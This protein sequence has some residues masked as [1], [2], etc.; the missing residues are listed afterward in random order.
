M[1]EGRQ[2]ELNQDHRL[3]G[4]KKLGATFSWSRTTVELDLQAI[5]FSSSGAPLG[6]VAYSNARALDGGLR[7][8]GDGTSGEKMKHDREVWVYLELMPDDVSLIVFVGA[9]VEKG[10]LWHVE[11]ARFHLIQDGGEAAGELGSLSLE[12]MSCQ[13]A[14]LG[15]LRRDAGGWVVRATELL[16]KDGQ[17]FVDILEPTIGG[18]VRGVIAGAPNL[19]ESVFQLDQGAIVELPRTE[20]VHHVCAGLSWELPGG[21]TADLDVSAIL[22]DNDGKELC[23]VHVEH[24]A[25]QGMQL[26]APRS[27]PRGLR[28]VHLDLEA[29]AP[30]VQ[31]LFFLLNMTS[32]GQLADQASSVTCRIFTG[33]SG[34]QREFSSFTCA[35]QEDS[36]QHGLIVARLF[37]A[38]GKLRWAFEAVGSQC[39]GTS[40]AESLPEV[41]EYASEYPR[42]I[43]DEEE[44]SPSRSLYNRGS[45]RQSFHEDDD[46]GGGEGGGDSASFVG[47]SY[48]GA[49]FHESQ[50]WLQNGGGIFDHGVGEQDEEEAALLVKGEKLD[51]RAPPEPPQLAPPPQPEQA[52]LKPIHPVLA[53]TEPTFAM[54]EDACQCEVCSVQ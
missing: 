8:R 13:A 35:G 9:T 50:P 3:D 20:L 18:V 43:E 39:G 30:E 23:A 16:A 17:H 51:A 26:L 5:A 25:E 15:Y 34:K 42:G 19:E 12:S 53:T 47:P 38:P 44:A 2:L 22:M 54:K 49:S 32:G 52:S 14:V 41:E 24:L 37:R 6:A 11:D 36:D 45:F 4:A 21:Q 10:C 46:C 7:H 33:E 29:L 1:V 27:D 28:A 48:M 40:C 31:Q